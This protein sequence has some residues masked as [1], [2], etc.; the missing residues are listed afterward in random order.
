MRPSMRA[1]AAVT[2]ALG[3]IGPIAGCSSPEEAPSDAHTSAPTP[4][5][6]KPAK[7]PKGDVKAPVIGVGKS[8]T[9]T[10]VDSYSGAKTTMSVT[11]HSVKYVTPDEIGGSTPKGRFAVLTVE[12]KNVGS[13]D[14]GFHPY[15]MMKWEDASTAAQEASTL[16]NTGT[17]DVDTTYHP[18]QA[19]TGDVVLDV[20]RKGGK[21]LYR[22]QLG[23]ES[24]VFALPS[25]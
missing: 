19:V 3:I 1:C 2:V 12:V 11:L 7:A 6:E 9:Y 16:E 5:Q 13:K 20:P 10:T 25:K 15:G 24:I 22:D 17:Q 21:A 18:G 8:G 14:G 4:K 23:P